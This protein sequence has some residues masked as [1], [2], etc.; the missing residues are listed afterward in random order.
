MNTPS[1]NPSVGPYRDRRTALL[2]AGVLEIIL[3]AGAWLMVALMV[4]GA[5]MAAAHGAASTASMIPGMAVYG[6]AGLV[7]VILGIGS[8]RA[9]RWARALWLVVGTS[10]LMVGILGVASMA[11][12]MPSVLAGAAPA[13]QQ[14]PPGVQSV[15]VITMISFMAVFMIGLPAGFLVFYRSPHVKATCEAENPRPCWTDECPLPV[16]GAALWLAAMTLSLPWMG[17]AYGGLYPFF[18]HFVR[19][20]AGHGLWVLSGLLS[21][22]A[23]FGVYR[24]ISA[25]WLLAVVLVLGLGISTT[26]TYAV[27]D[28]KVLYGAMGIEGAQ[29]EQIERMG[30]LRPSYMVAS[31]A[32]AILPLLGLL[33]WARAC[34]PR[35]DAGVSVK[36][37]GSSP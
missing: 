27:A 22:V 21:G 7:F 18:G 20:A 17:L 30:L 15:I 4:L 6:M 19:G 37:P 13:G 34:F 24:R 5:S 35:P 26:V 11:V 8:I 31:T 33:L 12:I 16:L 2:V 9:R 36:P 14:P 3:G 25:L 28:L 1:T 10:W 32:A 23:A 29:L